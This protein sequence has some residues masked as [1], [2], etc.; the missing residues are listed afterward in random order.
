MRPVLF[1]DI[2]TT[3]NLDALVYLPEPMAPGNYKDADK[4]AQYVIEKKAEQIAH[5][6]RFPT[7][8]FSPINT[9]KSKDE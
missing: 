5:V 6:E 7:S 4:I 9:R 1:F 8:F 3:A 2:E